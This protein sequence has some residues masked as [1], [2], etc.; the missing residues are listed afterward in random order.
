MLQSAQR[1]HE[2][3]ALVGDAGRPMK[4]G[5][6]W[7]MAALPVRVVMVE[8][9]LT[10]YLCFGL[11]DFGGLLPDAPA[12]SVS[13]QHPLTTQGLAR[14]RRGITL[15]QGMGG[16]GGI[17]TNKKAC[18]GAST[19]VPPPPRG[20]ASAAHTPRYEHTCRFS[21]LSSGHCLCILSQPLVV[22]SSFLRFSF[23]IY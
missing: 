4:D 8:H 9:L 20:Q 6:G 12:P 21:S 11:E 2:P 16:R 19:S 10:T 22:H 3:P 14:R 15:Q 7:G 18:Q 17:V 1:Y 13:P 5:R 23:I